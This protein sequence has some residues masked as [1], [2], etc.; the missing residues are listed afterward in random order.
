MRQFEFQTFE[1]HIRNFYASQEF[2]QKEK[3]AQPFFTAVKD[4][5]FG[6]PLTLENAVCLLCFSFDVGYRTD[7][8]DFFS[9]T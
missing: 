9:G 6:R 8:T 3:A 7:R 1:K 2:K 4:Y 5:V